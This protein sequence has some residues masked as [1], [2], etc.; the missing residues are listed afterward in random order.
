M[1][2]GQQTAHLC[3]CNLGHICAG[4]TCLGLPAEPALI[5]ADCVTRYR[6]LHNETHLFA[7]RCISQR[8]SSTHGYCLC[9]ECIQARTYFSSFTAPRGVHTNICAWCTEMVHTNAK[10][11]TNS[12][13]T[14]FDQCYRSVLPGK[15]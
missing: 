8:T 5:R 15:F 7:L 12:R 2:N 6:L 10:F 14:L 4:E 1:L 11:A 9:V 13:N 3:L